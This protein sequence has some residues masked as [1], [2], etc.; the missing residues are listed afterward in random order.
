MC[1]RLVVAGIVGIVGA[2]M[3]MALC[4]WISSLPVISPVSLSLAFTPWWRHWQVAVGCVAACLLAGCALEV[5]SA[6]FQTSPSDD[7][8]LRTAPRRL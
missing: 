2:T 1:Y 5:R 7:E 8:R 4:Y 6:F 3:W